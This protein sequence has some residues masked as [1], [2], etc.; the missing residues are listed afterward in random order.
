MQ[1][2]IGEN[3]AENFPSLTTDSKG[4]QIRESNR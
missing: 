2:A 4:E 3:Y 1:P